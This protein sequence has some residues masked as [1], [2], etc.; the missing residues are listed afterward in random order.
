MTNAQIAEYANQ[1]EA[2]LIKDM[3]EDEFGQYS[4]LTRDQ[5]LAF[6]MSCIKQGTEFM[7]AQK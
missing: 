5:K 2:I 4:N 3:N 6:V 1:F 7:A